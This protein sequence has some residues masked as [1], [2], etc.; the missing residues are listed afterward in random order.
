MRK[1]RPGFR[2]RTPRIA[3]RE[4]EMSSKSRV[5]QN[6]PESRW[7]RAA[8]ECRR[9]QGLGMEDLYEVLKD[10]SSQENMVEDC[11]YETVNEI[12]EVTQLHSQVGAARQVEVNFRCERASGA[13]GQQQNRSGRSMPRWTETKVRQSALT[14]RFFW[15]FM[16]FRRGGP[17]PVPMS[18]G[19]KMKT[20]R[21]ERV[22]QEKRELMRGPVKPTRWASAILFSSAL[23]PIKS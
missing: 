12:K 5:A 6:S 16:W 21:R 20:F 22:K 15:K 3:H 23:V 18:F 8:T 11:L 2:L 9:E 1:S 7:T 17:A 14:R 13:T 19:R 4:A 10:S